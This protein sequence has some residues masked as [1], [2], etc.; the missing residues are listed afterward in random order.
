MI[1][2]QAKGVD[3]VTESLDPFLNQKVEACTILIIEENGSAAIAAQD[4]VIECSRIVDPWLSWHATR[5]HHKLQYSKPDPIIFSSNRWESSKPFSPNSQ[6]K[7]RSSEK[8][9][10]V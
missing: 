6:L 1:A 5:L 7:S 3:A 4:D 9:Y 2:H 10:P 8:R